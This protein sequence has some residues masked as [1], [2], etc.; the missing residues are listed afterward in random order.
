[1][2]RLQT[3]ILIG[4]LVATGAGAAA[5]TIL[6][7]YIQGEVNVA[8]SQPLQVER[9]DVT[10]I[11]TGR[12]WFGA[13]SDEGTEFSAAVQLYQGEDAVIEV[14]IINRA[15]VDHVVEIIVTAP[16]LPVPSGGNPSDYSINLN[17]RGSGAINDVVQVGP[18]KWKC[19][20][21]SEA[22]GRSN[23]STPPAFD[24]L[25][26]TVALGDMVPP[27]FY[28]ISGQIQVVAY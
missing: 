1:M 18:Y 6:S 9:P 13:V 24:G 22:G 21:D 20:V 17:V 10:G 26:I 7:G 5:G 27:G 28:E 12:A 2:R 4:A 19:T 23:P 25:K 11:P 3:W 8:V 16:V 15:E 14:P